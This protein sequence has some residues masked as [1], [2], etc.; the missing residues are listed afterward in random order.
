MVIFFKSLEYNFL[1]HCYYDVQHPRKGQSFF[2]LRL[3]RKA[4]LISGEDINIIFIKLIRVSTKKKEQKWKC[5]ILDLFYRYFISIS[6]YL[7][8]IFKEYFL[9]NQYSLNNTKIQVYIEPLYEL[10]RWHNYQKKSLTK[11]HYFIPHLLIL[12]ST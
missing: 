7:Y 6:K 1:R 4:Y 12:L 11:P 8:L 3:G 9:I 2:G 10:F 5:Q